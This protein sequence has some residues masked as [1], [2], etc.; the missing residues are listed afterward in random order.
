MIKRHSGAGFEKLVKDAQQMTAENFHT[1]SLMVIAKYFGETDENGDVFMHSNEFREMELKL[2]DIENR[3]ALA[4]H[5]P[6]D[7]R[8]VRTGLYFRMMELTNQLLTA[9]EQSALRASL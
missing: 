2:Q 6:G 7:L 4:G 8:E 9:D 3:Q 1:V 5:M